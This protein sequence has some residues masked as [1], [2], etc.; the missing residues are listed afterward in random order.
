V[1]LKFSSVVQ[2]RTPL[3]VRKRAF[4]PGFRANRCTVESFNGAVEK[5]YVVEALSAAFFNSD[6]QLFT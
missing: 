1:P 6:Q 4:L 5:L 2:E 3:P